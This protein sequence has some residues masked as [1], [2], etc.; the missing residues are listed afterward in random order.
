LCP[1]HLIN[2]IFRSSLDLGLSQRPQSKD[3]HSPGKGFRQFRQPE[4]I[5]R[6]CQE[7]AARTSV[8]V[9]R[10]LDCG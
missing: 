3:L 1:E 9:D 5:G 4:D 10:G 2:D 7:K 8:P 6:P